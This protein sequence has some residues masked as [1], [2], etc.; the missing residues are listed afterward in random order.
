MNE[1]SSL[2]V[3]PNPSQGLTSI[4]FTLDHAANVSLEVLNG[5]GQLVSTLSN[6]QLGEGR[7]SFSFNAENAVNGL[8]LIRLTVD[9]HSQ[10]QRLLLTR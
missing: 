9:G 8:Y 5:L 6:G 7:H 2:S 4:G 3:Y 1:V 10:T